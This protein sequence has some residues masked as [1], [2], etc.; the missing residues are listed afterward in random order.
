MKQWWTMG[1]VGAAGAL[2][3][4]SSGCTDTQAQGKG[5]PAAAPVEVARAVT[6]EV[7]AADE[8]SGRIEATEAVD[9]RPRV[10][11]IIEQVNFRDGQ[12]VTRGQLLFTLDARPFAA[13]V[14]RTEAQLA[15]AQASAALAAS[16]VERARPL[17]AIKAVSQQEFD[18]LD[19]TLRSAQAN[20]RAAEATVQTARLNLGYT[21]I[22]APIAGRASRAGVT[23]GNL[24]NANESVLTSIVS[25]DR[26][27][28]YFDASERVYLRYL[29]QGK[30]QPVD[31]AA[32]PQV[33]MALATDTEFRHRGAVD[34]VDNRLNAQT[35]AIRARA[36][37]DNRERQFTPGLF[38][39][40]RVSGGEAAPAVLVPDVAIGTQQT[41]RFVLVVGADNTV[42]WREVT[43]GALVNG[44]RVIES[45]LKADENVIVS[46]LQRVRPGQTV[47]PTPV[48]PKTAAAPAAANPAR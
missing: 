14:A 10:T 2:A 42:Q 47:A 36:V 3:I 19:S 32:R 7:R 41:K 28:A 43:P 18:Q 37:F 40:V 12:E 25:L 23:A 6:R 46:G 4:V 20:A 38:A 34:F 24:V 17:L 22:R 44:E 16:E 5:A 8:F 9:V 33:E 1:A 13:E 27:Y 30:R 29:Q 11:G 48:A 21:E 31:P 39:R 45:G 15:A 35:G 26:V